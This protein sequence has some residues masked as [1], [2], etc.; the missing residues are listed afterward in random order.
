MEHYRLGSTR[1]I[2]SR[3]FCDAAKID[4]I[5][6]IERIFS[7]NME[8][9]RQYELSMADVTQEEFVR[10]KMEVIDKVDEIAE[11]IFKARSQGL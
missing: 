7:E 11:R 5:E 1:A 3:S 9:L 4:S 8:K 10:N 6:E 2:L